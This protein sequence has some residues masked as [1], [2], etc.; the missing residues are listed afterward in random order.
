MDEL[1]KNKSGRLA[2]WIALTFI[3]LAESGYLYLE[4]LDIAGDLRL[5]LI[6]PVE[7]A[8]ICM[9]G[10]TNLGG[11]FSRSLYSSSNIAETILR[12]VAFLIVLLSLSLPV[13]LY[14][15]NTTKKQKRRCIFIETV[16]VLWTLLTL[17]VGW[18]TVNM[19]FP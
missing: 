2:F 19:N 9:I 15:K 14:H 8:L 7:M 3:V 10:E 18:V 17:W 4:L 5:I 16:V 1:K 13:Y 11:V 12:C 6:S